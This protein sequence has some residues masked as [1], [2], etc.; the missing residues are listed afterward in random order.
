MRRCT[1][2]GTRR[3]RRRA[4]L[5][6]VLSL[7]AAAVLSLNHYVNTTVKP[8]LHELAEYEARSATTQA[9]N[10][11]VAAILADQPELFTA[12]YRQSGSLFCLD[13]AAAN[14]AQVQLVAAIQNEMD[15]LSEISYRVPFGSL[16]NNSLL[17]G[18]GPGWLVQ[19]KPVG[20]VQGQ[21]VESVADAAIN[22]V[23]Y[24]AVFS[25]S[26]TVNMILDGSTATLTVQ[27]D[28]PLT[29][30]LVQGTAPDFY[31]AVPD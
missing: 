20:Y 18:L 31:A 9:V 27:A 6:F 13:T 11:A 10:R 16:T 24:T 2:Q 23:R 5:F 14:A 28:Y 8:T 3:A 21:I 22:T 7:F 15:A 12:L 19:I 26:V 1:V 17:S 30:V 25:A 29:S 4:G